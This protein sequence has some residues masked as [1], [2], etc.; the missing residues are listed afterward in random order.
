VSGF[1]RGAA[2]RGLADGEEVRCDV[3]VVGT[4]AGGAV[5]AAGL[6]A[7]GLDVVVLEE[8]GAH[9]SAAFRRLD[10]AWSYPN[11]YQERGG[12]A[13]VDLA[14]T[15][16]QGR[17]VG[18]GT[19]VNWTTCFRTP[20]RVLDH[21]RR[22]HGLS[23][24]E[25][26]LAPHFDAVEARLG[27]ERWEAAPPN[28]NN[29]ALWRAAERLGWEA[30]R[31][32]RNVRGCANSGYCGF[33]CPVDAKQAMHLTYVPD[34]V[35]AG[36][37]V[38]ADTRA[39]ALVIEGTRVRT[40][41]A[42]AMDPERDAPAEPSL[43]FTVRADRVAVCGGAINS[44]ALLLRSGV[45]D[46]PV[47]RRTWLHPVV[48]VGGRYLERIDGWYG[49]PQSV[50]SHEFVD[51]GDEIGFF[52]EHA[53]IH[54]MLAGVSLPGFGAERAR[55]LADLAFSASMIAIHVDGMRPDEPG[56]TVSLRGGGRVALDY[57]VVPALSAA[58]AEAHR[59]MARAHLAAGAQ[60]VYTLHREP[61]RI[62]AGEP[63]T[64]LDA[65]PYGANRVSVFSAH[66]MGGCAMGPDPEASVVDETLRHH[67]V[68]NLWV[69]DGSVL[70]TGLGVNPSETIYG[71]AHWATQ[72]VASS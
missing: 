14:I 50:S 7:R 23:L 63:L 27:I 26:E 47:G 55:Q 22:A 60:E 32:R 34:A 21:W 49:A 43:R 62:A 48:S 61:L 20:P 10:E 51:R 33:G 9:T 68:E 66:Q 65:A 11:L 28:A 25:A 69:V 17:S 2:D 44:P 70:P 41:R 12:R 35:R 37:R 42:V 5:L 6:A 15:V 64:A 39:E 40:V 13:T 30:Q 29:A 72:H 59:V 56:G 4:G 38:W 36:A 46:G 57:P 45:T 18:G 8:G 16:L 24:T 3:C 53:P 58:F 1:V 19:T 52:L 67:R 54:P 71:I 31:T